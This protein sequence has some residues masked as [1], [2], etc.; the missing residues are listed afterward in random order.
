MGV[1]FANLSR[2]NK[3]RGQTAFDFF[4]GMSVFLV[5]LSIVLAFVPTMVQ[6]FD[7]EAG[8]NMVVA[9]RSAALLAEDLL[10]ADVASPGVLNTT[11]TVDFF[12][13]DPDVADCRFTQDGSNLVDALAVD[14]YTSV[15][16]TVESAG[17]VLTVDSH[18][19]QAGRS[20]P[21]T[22]DVVSARRAVLVDG[23]RA[24][25]RVRVW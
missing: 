9:D 24:I 17:T 12:D 2:G 13:D 11:C 22:A 5:T 8:P 10:V 23:S 15:N 6:P 20:P 21:V 18:A 1:S 14:P 7:S 16:V 25:L 19:L 3:D 4:V